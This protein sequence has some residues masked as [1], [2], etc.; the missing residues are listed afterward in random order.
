MARFAAVILFSVPVHNESIRGHLD[1]KCFMVMFLRQGGRYLVAL[2][3]E[4]LPMS[5]L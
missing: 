4:L 2:K 5:L 3:T 1:V